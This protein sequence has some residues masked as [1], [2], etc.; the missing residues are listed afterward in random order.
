M[1]LTCGNYFTYIVDFG[2]NSGEGEIYFNGDTRYKQN[3]IPSNITQDIQ[4]INQLSAGG[5]HTA[6][7]L[8]DGTV[9][10]WG[11][12][13][14]GQCLGTDEN[15]N[16]K[17]STTFGARTTINGRALTNIVKIV[18]GENHTCALNSLG[19]VI[20]WG[21][22]NRGQCTVPSTLFDAVDVYAKGDT[23]VAIK[24]DGSI[25]MW[26]D[27]SKDKNNIPSYAK[28]TQGSVFSIGK[29]HCILLANKTT[30]EIPETTAPLTHFNQYVTDYFNNNIVRVYVTFSNGDNDGLS[31]GTDIDGEI[32]PYSRSEAGKLFYYNNDISGDNP[33][34][35]FYM[36]PNIVEETSYNLAY[37]GGVLSPY[38]KIKNEMLTN[39]IQ[40]TSGDGFI[41]ALKADGNVVAWGKNNLGECD[42][43]SS[44][45]TV[46]KI[47]SWETGSFA[48]KQDGSIVSWGNTQN[49]PYS[50]FLTMTDVENYS[51]G[52]EHILIL[53][54]NGTIITITKGNDTYSLKLP[55]K[56]GKFTSIVSG[57]DHI[58]ALLDDGTVTCWGNNSYNQC[59]VPSGLNNVIQITCGLYLSAGS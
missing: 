1:L 18:A 5:Y 56:K 47:Y 38:V 14:N 22:N 13:T 59:D 36:T 26:G 17:I 39:V 49:F 46:K 32:L 50:S 9:V 21:D 6:A 33:N 40:L 48:L 31:I 23:T 3:E 34:D 16:A 8:L 11:K 45:N 55:P 2:A 19:V 41:V 51:F 30:Q 37:K 57:Y 35:T 43:P 20:C 12:N 53:K 28:F 52:N 44:A 27:V 58:C 15:G 4:N 7:L 10:C 25:V 29:E 54:K 42:V 24:R